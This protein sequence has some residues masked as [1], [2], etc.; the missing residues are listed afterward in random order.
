MESMSKQRDAQ[1]SERSQASESQECSSQDIARLAYA[2]WQQRGCPQGSS[3][4]DWC[5]AEQQ[6]CSPQDQRSRVSR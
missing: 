5:E 2:L 6:L 1:S 3:E 4:Q